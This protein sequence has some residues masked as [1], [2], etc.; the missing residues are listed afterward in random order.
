MITKEDINKDY[1]VATEAAQK[2]NVNNSRIR[3]LCIAGR[4]EGAFK[5]GE[6]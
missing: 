2:L 5:I 1:V 6:T 4:F 3:Q